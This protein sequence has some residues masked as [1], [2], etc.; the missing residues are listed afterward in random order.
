MFGLVCVGL[1][2]IFKFVFDMFR[3]FWAEKIK[4][5]VSVGLSLRVYKGLDC[6]FCLVCVVFLC[7]LCM[8]VLI[9]CFGY[10]YFVLIV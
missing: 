4:E 1:C 8:F 7:V 2:L 5:D 9:C 6:L 3:F 10:F